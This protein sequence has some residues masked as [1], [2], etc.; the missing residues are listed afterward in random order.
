MR[1][2]T[3]DSLALLV[4]M[5]KDPQDREHSFDILVSRLNE[6]NGGGWG[7]F[8]D[9]ERRLIKKA[10]KPEYQLDMEKRRAA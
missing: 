1:T 8:S 3:L 6:V 4:V 5:L 9:G 10:F 7:G 2:L